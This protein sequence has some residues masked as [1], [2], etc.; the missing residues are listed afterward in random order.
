MRLQLMLNVSQS[1]TDNMPSPTTT[2]LPV[3]RSWDEFEDICAD[4]L[5]RMWG[6]PYITRNGRSGQKQHGVD[7][8]GT[9]THFN[10]GSGPRVFSAAQC[11]NT[12][13]LS[14]SEIADEVKKAESFSPQPAEYLVLTTAPRDASLQADVRN[15]SWPFRVE[16][17]FWED[18]SLEL[19]GHLD[20]LQK[21]FPTWT[22]ATVGTEDVIARVLSSAPEDYQY[23]DST[24]VFL[25]RHDVK[26]R[27]IFDRSDESDRA[28]DE[29]WVREFPDPNASRQIVYVE[30]DGARVRTFYFVWVDG[31]RYLLPYPKS[32]ND[33]RISQ[34]QY[35]VGTILSHPFHGYSFD[36]GLAC[37]RIAVDAGLDTSSTTAG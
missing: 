23:N 31:A 12:D 5:R 33:L 15:H 4:L 2:R 32:R 34:A 13:N 7:I 18:L 22:K 30:Y 8:Y 14:L 9:P 21:H 20:L 19:S 26:L 10:G 36:D 37:A 3:P 29:P 6:D 35:H 16:V 17:R 27:L 25:H 28:F 24:G 1:T 11:K